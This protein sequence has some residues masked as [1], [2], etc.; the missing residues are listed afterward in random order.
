MGQF[1]G[2]KEIRLLGVDNFYHYLDTPQFISPDINNIVINQ[3]QVEHVATNLGFLIG[4]C[5]L[6]N[7]KI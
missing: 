6:A 2:Y 3:P 4:K 1:M 7:I 5:K